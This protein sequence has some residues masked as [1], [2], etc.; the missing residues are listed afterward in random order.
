MLRLLFDFTL[1]VYLRLRV[2]LLIPCMAA[3]VGLIKL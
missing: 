2:C 1:D 3:A